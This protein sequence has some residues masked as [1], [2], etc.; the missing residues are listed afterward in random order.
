[1]TIHPY[2]KTS[3]Q[4]VLGRN[5]VEVAEP[6]RFGEAGSRRF[7]FDA[8]WTGEKWVRGKSLAI[9]FDSEGDAVA[10]LDANAARMQDAGLRQIPA[11]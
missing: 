10:Y 9:T 6:S 11:I 8:F 1:M 3:R 2:R 7:A 5:R 4:W